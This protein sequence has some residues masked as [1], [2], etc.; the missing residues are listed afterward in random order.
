[1]K[2]KGK[3]KLEHLKSMSLKIQEAISKK[4]LR[5]LTKKEN[6]MSDKLYIP[7]RGIYLQNLPPLFTLQMNQ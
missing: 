5:S 2:G 7:T 4:E 3:K 1:M 6:N